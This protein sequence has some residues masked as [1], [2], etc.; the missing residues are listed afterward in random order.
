MNGKQSVGMCG[1]HGVGNVRPLR[2]EEGTVFGLR[3]EAGTGQGLPARGAEHH[4]EK[5]FTDC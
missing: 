5:H 1:E 3:G 4:T 2:K